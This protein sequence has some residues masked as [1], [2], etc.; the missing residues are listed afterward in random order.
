M[1]YRFLDRFRTGPGWSCSKAVYKPVWHTPLLSVHW[2][3]SWWWIEELSETCRFSCQNKF[4]KLVHLVGFI[5]KKHNQQFM[6]NILFR[7]WMTDGKILKEMWRDEIAI[8]DFSWTALWKPE[9][10][11]G[12]T[13]FYSANIRVMTYTRHCRVVSPYSLN[14]DDEYDVVVR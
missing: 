11:W 6:S 14:C 3:N 2:I 12:R 5:I 9:G 7:H 10:T 4:V 13:S 1:S 8:P